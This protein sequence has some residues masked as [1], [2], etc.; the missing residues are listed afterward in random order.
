M[1]QLL[2][3]CVVQVHMRSGINVS[4]KLNQTQT[5]RFSGLSLHTHSYLNLLNFTVIQGSN[6]TF[7]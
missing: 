5:Q 7:N 6:N 1:L 4:P 3:V 2:N